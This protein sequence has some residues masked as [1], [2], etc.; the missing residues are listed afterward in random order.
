MNDFEL[1]S[2]LK[3]VPLPERSPDYWE[4]FPSQVRANL[5]HA[6][7]E[8]APRNLLLSQLAWC[9]GFALACAL[10]VLAL[11][12]SYN[13]LLKKER[14]F[15]HQL[16]ELPTHLRVLMSDE[17]GLHYLVAGKE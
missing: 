1:A 13:V 16:A 2:K 10:F 6:P 17:H 8:L 3:R 7:I 15:R 4:N 11:W 12:P 5:R 9:G 14:T